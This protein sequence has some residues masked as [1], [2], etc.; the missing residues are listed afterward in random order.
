[1]SQ[2]AAIRR[3]KQWG[4]KF[5]HLAKIGRPVYAREVS[6]DKARRRLMQLIEKQKLMQQRKSKKV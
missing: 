4:I 3:R 5:R 2:R 6:T 1:M